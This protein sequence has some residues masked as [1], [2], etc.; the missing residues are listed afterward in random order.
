MPALKYFIH[1]CDGY[2]GKVMGDYVRNHA[3]PEEQPTICGSLID[4]RNKPTWADEVVRS[5]DL[6]A[7]KKALLTADVIIYDVSTSPKDATSALKVLLKYDYAENPEDETEKVMIGVSSLLSWASNST[8]KPADGEEPPEMKV[9]TSVEADTRK[10]HP[11]YKGQV[12]VENLIMNKGNQKKDKLRTYIVWS[13]LLYGCGE[14]VLHSLFQCSWLGTHKAMPVIGNGANKIPMIHVKDLAGVVLAVADKKPNETNSILAVDQGETPL[15]EV[16]RAISKVLQSGEVEQYSLD[17]YLEFMAANKEPHANSIVMQLNMRMSML[18]EGVPVSVATALGYGPEAEAWHSGA[19]LVANIEKVVEEYREW[20]NLQPVRVLFYGP[21]GTDWFPGADGRLYLA[22]DFA[23]EY[24]VTYIDPKGLIEEYKAL[25]SFAE[26]GSDLS[27]K[28]QEATEEGGPGV[29]EELTLEMVKRKLQTPVCRN[30]GFVLDNFPTTREMA[31]KLLDVDRIPAEG[32]APPEEA[33]AEVAE[34]EEPNAKLAPLP[35]CVFV[36][37]GGSRAKPEAAE[38]EDEKKPPEEEWLISKIS[39]I[40]KE[41][42]EASGATEEDVYAKFM[43]DYEKFKAA[44]PV[45]EDGIQQGLL[46][47]YRDNKE[48]GVEKLVDVVCDNPLEFVQDQLRMTLGAPRNY[49]PE[50]PRVER[51]ATDKAKAETTAA[52]ADAKR[53][54]EEEASRSEREAKAKRDADNL[55]KLREEERQALMNRSKPMRTYL[56]ENVLPTLT[57]GLQEVAQVRPDDPID[58]LAEYLFNTDPSNV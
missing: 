56:M 39:S 27:K 18:A 52:A 43:E 55:A 44:N 41:E 50:R 15:L 7:L 46:G 1:E 20:R 23:Q 14:G 10:P 31:G 21:P 51:E 26:G 2:F 48:K 58:Y 49:D 12:T 11:N 17:K 28:L 53:Q 35:N 37:S 42:A 38:G 4:P 16:A 24:Q 47:L 45:D 19:G 32:E 8:P 13:G 25:P 3:L 36:L 54:A 22:K 57:K 29:S 5:D 30:Q 6:L 34:G 40:Q 9:L 33:P